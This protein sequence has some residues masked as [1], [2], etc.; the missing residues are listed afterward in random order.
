M[1][2]VLCGGFSYDIFGRRIT[3]FLS[4]IVCS[5]AAFIMPYTAPSLYPGLL[6]AKIVTTM[7]I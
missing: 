7:V 6:L 1:V 3:I 5:I 4:F 2:M